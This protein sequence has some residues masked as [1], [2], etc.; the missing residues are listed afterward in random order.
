[1]KVLIADKFQKSGIDG[2][3]ALGCTVVSL[4]DIAADQVGAAV[5]EHDPDVLVVR[6]T[7]VFADVFQKAKKL[8]L[9]VRA[10]A[11]YDNIDLDA[12]SA[13]GI[14]VANCPGKNAIAVA[15]LA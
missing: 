3:E 6:S 14:S 9:V 4:P 5:V 11:G 12:A 7:K 1:M 2:L 13:A 10:G 8:A 15:E